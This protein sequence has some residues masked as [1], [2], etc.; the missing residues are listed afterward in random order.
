MSMIGHNRPPFE[1]HSDLPQELPKM[2]FFKCDITALRKAIIDKP[3][4]VRGAFVSVLLALYEHMEPLPADDHM[5]ML[6]TGIHNTKLWRRVKADLIKLELI[7]V[8]P[9]GRL[10]NARFQDE[11]AAY[12]SEFKNRQKAALEREEKARLARATR[13]QKPVT[14]ADKLARNSLATQLQ[15]PCNPVASEFLG[16]TNSIEN[17]QKN[18]SDAKKINEINGAATTSVAQPS[19][20]GDHETRIRARVLELE[21]DNRKEEREEYSPPAIPPVYP[22]AGGLASDD[23]IPGLNG[24]TSV[25]VKQLATWLS[26]FAPDFKTASRMVGEW[27]K[28]YSPDAV[29]DGF[30]DYSASMVDGG[31]RTPSAKSILGFIRTAHDG[32]K[33][34]SASSGQGR[35]GNHRQGTYKPA[36][37]SFAAEAMKPRT[38][39]QEIVIDATPNAWVKS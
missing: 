8:T 33:K 11:I 28:Q 32:R 29:R 39:P 20:Q 15:P 35:S 34:P 37:G 4:D 6:R 31:V 26:P 10:T 3:L 38:V 17:V 30:A 18:A 25:I 9:N 19:P 21:L 2:H 27:V 1:D 36:Y 13:I 16:P 12:V 14:K 7:Q 23:D 24:A 5:A 22:R